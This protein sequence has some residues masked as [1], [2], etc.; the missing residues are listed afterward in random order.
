MAGAYPPEGRW[1]W[2]KDFPWQPVPIQT[3]PRKVDGMLNPSSRCPAAEE[4]L[5]KVRRS[6]EVQT[7]TEQYKDLF[8]HLTLNTGANITDIIQAENVYDTL[9]IEGE[10]NMALP[11]WVDPR[12]LTPLKRITDYTFYF[13]FSTKLL[14]R[15]RA[16]LFFKDLRHRLSFAVNGVVDEVSE[17]TEGVDIKKMF[18]YSTV[19]CI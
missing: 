11:P 16:G 6:P 2:K 13:D 10:N 9:F 17:L 4:E 14:Q 7:F 5:S 15:L 12:I 3:E 19:S 18:I 8:S 1:V